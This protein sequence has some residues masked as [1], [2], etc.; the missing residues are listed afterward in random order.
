MN[1]LQPIVYTRPYRHNVMDYCYFVLPEILKGSRNALLDINRHIKNVL[2]VESGRGSIRGCR[3]HVYRFEDYVL[4][5]VATESFGRRDET[6]VPIRGYY[7]LLMNVDD[8]FIPPLSMFPEVDAKFVEPHFYDYKDF[9]VC[10]S[11]NLLMGGKV[12]PAPEVRGGSEIKFNL[13][14]DKLMFLAEDVSVDCYLRDALKA[15]RQNGTFEFVYGFNTEDH[16]RELEVMNVVC[17]GVMPKVVSLSRG[18]KNIGQCLQDESVGQNATVPRQEDT[19]LSKRRSF[20]IEYAEED[21]GF[22]TRLIQGVTRTLVWFD[23]HID[24]RKQGKEKC[25]IYKRCGDRGCGG[26]GEECTAQ[27]GKKS[28]KKAPDYT[29][30]MSVERT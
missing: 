11:P 16:S 30:G 28:V 15:A 13:A 4:I 24:R 1:I 22:F 7:G 21:E 27:Y 9:D 26:S 10:Y 5:G 19:S 25:R 20:G 17:Y 18:E 3:W 6:G 23:A 29:F 8:A 12:K 2:A 14:K